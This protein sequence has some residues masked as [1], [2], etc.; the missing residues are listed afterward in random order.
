MYLIRLRPKDLPE[1]LQREFEA[2]LH[3]LTNE[4]AAGDEGTIQATTRKLTSEEGTELA[5]RILHIIPSFMAASQAEDEI[6]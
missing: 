2:L 5:R 4:K 1:E 3:D 6:F